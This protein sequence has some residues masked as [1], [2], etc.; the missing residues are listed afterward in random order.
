[1]KRVKDNDVV[2]GIYALA[3][4]GLLLVPACG[5]TR[6]DSDVGSTAVKL[7]SAPGVTF[8]SPGAIDACFLTDL[9]QEE[10]QIIRRSIYQTWEFVADI[11]LNWLEECPSSGSLVRVAIAQKSD[12]A[13][14]GHDGWGG[15]YGVGALRDERARN[16]ANVSDPR[17]EKPSFKV[18][19]GALGTNARLEYLGAHEFGHVL[20]FQDEGGGDLDGDGNKPAGDRDDCDIYALGNSAHGNPLTDYDIDSIMNYCNRYFNGRGVL[21]SLDIEGVQSVYGIG[22]RYTAAIASLL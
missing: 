14:E 9:Y 15:G 5:D 21:T 20:G 12:F 11:E 19:L 3:V 1:M 6:F 16:N 22:D 4:F 13:T 17:P 7:T 18:W 10:Q 8:L 2:N